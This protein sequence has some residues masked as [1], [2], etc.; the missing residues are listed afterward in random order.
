MRP[1]ASAATRRASRRPPAL[2]PCPARQRFTSP[3]AICLYIWALSD[4]TPMPAP[5]PPPKP[6]PPAPAP[7]PAASPLHP[8]GQRQQRPVPRLSEVTGKGL[9]AHRR[10]ACRGAAIP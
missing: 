8:M 5:T 2:R 1:P 7:K 4:T 10:A 6:P 9:R 3:P